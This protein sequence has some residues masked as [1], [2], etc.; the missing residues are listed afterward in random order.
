MNQQY[1]AM[2]SNV[3]MLGK[4]LGDTIKDALGED[5]LDKV[6]SI[7]KLSKSSRAGNEVQRQKLLMTLQT[8]TNDELLPVARAFNQFLNLTNVAEQYHSISPH[9]EAASNPVALQKLF[10]RLKEHDFSHED[11]QKAVEELSIELVLT[12]HPTEIARRTLIHKLVEVNTCLS[13]LDHDDLA[14]YE[15]NNIMRRLRQ[16]VAQSWHTDEIRKIRPTPIDEAKWGFAVVENSLWEGVPAFLREFNEQLEESIGAQ[17]PVEAN[18]I[19]FTSWMGGDRDG[20]PN[21]TAEVTRH[22]LLLSRWKA[23]DLFLKDIQVLVSE[24]SMT[25]AT[26]ELRALAGGDEVDEPYR[27]IAK[28]LRSQL[29]STLE[30]LERRVKGEQVLPPADLLTDNAQLWDPLYACYQSL[31]A[32][33]MSII[34]NGSL[35]DTLRRIRSFGLQLVRID[36]RQESTR[37]TDA[38]SELT[39]YLGL[40]NYGDWSEQEK[41]DFLLTELQSRRPLI[42]QNW[43]P[44]PETQEVFET[45]RVIAKAKNDSIA[46]YV[47]SMAKVPSD[48]LAVKLLLK[49]AGAS[50]K[51]PVAPLFET[52][53]DL[54]NAESVMTKLLSIE[55]YRDLIDDRQMVMIGYSDSAKDAGVMAASWAQYRAQDALIKLCDKEGVK[56]TLFHGR[57]GTIGRGGAPAHSALLS[58]PPGSLK[59]GLRVTEQGEMIRFKFG[60]PQVTISSLAMYASAILEA[61]L[62]PPPEPKEAWKSVMNSLSDVSCAMYRDYVREQPDFVPYF[63]AATPELELGKLPLGSRPAKRRP[64]GGVETLRAIPWIFAWTQNR[65]MLPAWLGA[66]AALK[67]VIEKEGKQAVLDEMWQEWTFF[68]TRIAMLE[69]V[70]AK[71]DLWLA[72]YYDHCLVEKRLWPLGQKLRDQLSE[73]IKSVLAVSKDEALMADLPWIAESIALRNVYT[74]PL[75]VLQAELLQRSRQQEH[76]DP[77]VEQALMVT[78]AGVAAGMRNTG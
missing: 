24:L 16:L 75:N 53:E 15:R 6:E 59:G 47:I 5:I 56:L 77:R 44:T 14:D 49:E 27:Q 58:Q 74:D 32:C 13:Q 29:F 39:E 62:L 72:E 35:L 38:L 12:A 66:G 18:P 63:R 4:L 26:P 68:K 73:D 37:H 42:P 60:L 22:V 64:T 46:A 48:V 9:G 10:G 2:R 1:S 52:L 20:N 33:N 8:L 21:V 55:W 69:M 36:V 70:Y 50:I 51:L 78:I 19:R 30:Y 57:G 40:G 76:P 3:S 7:R 61:N 67:H 43:Q 45:C 71:A 54:N 11:I 34:A 28:N 25:E 41:Q 17:L 23:A 31:V 65:L